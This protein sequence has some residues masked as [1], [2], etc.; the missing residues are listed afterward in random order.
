M[1]WPHALP[2]IPFAD[3]RA[4]FAALTLSR[5]PGDSL[6]RVSSQALFELVVPVLEEGWQRSV[7]GESHDAV[8]H[9]AIDRL[10]TWRTSPVWQEL[11]DVRWGDDGSASIDWLKDL[12]RGDAPP[13]DINGLWFGLFRPVRNDR[14]TSDFY[15]S[16]SRTAPTSDWPCD[17]DWWS[18]GR[19]RCSVALEQAAALEPSD[20]SDLAWTINYGLGLLHVASTVVRLLT[21]VPQDL[22]LGAASLRHIALGHDSG[23]FNQVAVID[24][25]GVRFTASAVA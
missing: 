20:D 18:D 13:D 17:T 24:S 23:D 7:A 9:G 16:G 6:G 21:A 22:W 10:A 4:P 1:I 19:Y 5:D 25:T 3:E 2:P 14:D 11:R 8:M 12:L 15:I